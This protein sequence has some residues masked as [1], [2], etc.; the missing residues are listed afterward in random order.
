MHVVNAIRTTSP[1]YRDS[2]PLSETG[3]VVYASS[4]N[5]LSKLAFADKRTC[6]ICYDE[7]RAADFSD[8]LV[9]DLVT[10]LLLV[11]AQRPVSG[12]VNCRDETGATT[13]SCKSITHHSRKFATEPALLLLNTAP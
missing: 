4:C 5:G 12:I 2:K 11:D 13:T 10:V 3:L 7:A 8:D 9:V 1:D 6:E